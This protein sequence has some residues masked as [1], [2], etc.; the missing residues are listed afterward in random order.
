VEFDGD[1]LD[2]F[3][4]EALERG[5]MGGVVGE[6]ADLADAEVGED[7]AAETDLAEDALG[8]ARGDVLAGVAVAAMEEEAGGCGVVDS[9]AALGLVE[10]DESTATGCGDGGE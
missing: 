8:V 3:D 6:Q 5:D 7:L 9:E 10:V 4:A 1:V 2:D